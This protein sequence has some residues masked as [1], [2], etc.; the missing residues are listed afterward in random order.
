VERE[1]KCIKGKRVMKIEGER[2]FIIL[3][4]CTNSS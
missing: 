2:N 1:E 3:G 4:W